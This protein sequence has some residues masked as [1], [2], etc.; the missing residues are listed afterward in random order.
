MRRMAERGVA[1]SYLVKE[2][3]TLLRRSPPLSTIG[4]G[5]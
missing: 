1:G 5:S 3:F 2:A 4:C